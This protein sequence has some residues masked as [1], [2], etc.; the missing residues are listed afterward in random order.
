MSYIY[1]PSGRA[2]EYSPLALNHWTGCEH[3]CLYCYNKSSVYMAKHYKTA[4]TCK[5]RDINLKKFEKELAK[6]KYNEQVLLCFQGDP[7]TIMEEKLNWTTKILELLNEYD[8]PTAILT[9][10]GN[11]CLKDIELFKQFKNIKVGATLVF[12]DDKMA[13]MVEPGAAPT[14]ER[15]EALKI[16][17]AANVKTWVSFEPV[18]FPEDTLDMIAW[19]RENVDEMKIGKLNH[20]KAFEREI[21]LNI[22]TFKMKPIDWYTF[23]TDAV[24]LASTGSAKFYIKQDLREILEQGAQV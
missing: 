5:P 18:V 3:Q 22:P 11:R 15:I 14:S 19:A 7:Y 10:G 6:N 23:G 9:K 21:Q 20:E 8:V 1:K 17:R 24:S 13:K 12:K 16:L 2:F 4:D